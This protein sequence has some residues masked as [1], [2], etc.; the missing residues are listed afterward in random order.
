LAI[1]LGRRQLL[2]ASAGALAAITAARPPWPDT[3]ERVAAAG[4]G[5]WDELAGALG[6][7]LLRRGDPDFARI[8]RPW[9]LRYAGIL[10]AGIAR[11]ASAEDVRTCLLWVRA[12]GVPLVAR[13]GGH[14]YAG[15]STTTGLMLDLSP[16]NAVAY[17]AG[18]GLARLGGGARNAD[19]YTNLRP[20]GR[21]VTHGRCLGVGVAGL[22]LGGGIGFSQRLHGLTC[23]QLVETEVV[24]AAGD[25]LRCSASENADLFWACRGGG[26]GNFGINTS[27]TFQAFPVDSLTVF[28]LTWT[29]DLDTLLPVALDTL[30]DTPDRLG[31][32]L[33]VVNDGARLSL[34]L[35]GQLD[36]MPRELRGLL[37]PLYRAAAAAE[38]DVR[39]LPYWD[40]QEFLSEEGAPEYSHERSR[41]VER[42]M[43][44]EGS[45]II[46]AALR[47]WPGTHG[48]A[49]WKIF[50]AGRA[51]AA[52]PAD[53]TAYVHRAALMLSSI[54][55]EW[56]EADSVGTVARNEEW[57]AA[58]HE[59][60]R[61]VTSERS[62]QN[63]IDPAQTDFLHAYYG[64]NLPRLVQVKRRY[65]P[66]N[67]FSFPQGIP[68]ALG[69]AAPGRAERPIAAAVRSP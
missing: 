28:R 34:E 29:E 8:A 60:M 61:P 27:L 15:F 66:D 53:A 43:S 47:D 51:V 65:D 37:D 41:Y 10:P 64:A 5:P 31:C 30:P 23:D 20:L 24:T 69:D 67:L 18:T 22:T 50:L 6:G 16:M 54:E 19:I 40:S 14:S 55:L 46:L 48:A 7:G 11:C 39:V 2:K 49:V 17:D 12:N 25:V 33:S 4:R 56:T 58:F 62:Y 45:R 59:A 36:G 42:P 52:V 26:G 32:K 63:F 44:E 38:E 68:L 1:A 13:S 9:N 3:I 35:L 21:A 57:L